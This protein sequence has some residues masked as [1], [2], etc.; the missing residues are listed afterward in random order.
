[1]PELFP[2]NLDLSGRRTL[3]VGGGEVA[4]RKVQLLIAAGATVIVVSPQFCDGLKGLD[5]AERVARPFDPADLKGCTL[6]IAATD[7]P[8][9]NRRVCEEARLK[10]VLVN[11]VDKPALCDFYVAASIRRGRFCV[12]ISTGGASPALARRVRLGLEKTFPPVYA[13]FVDLLAELRGEVQQ[14][15]DDAKRRG[16]ILGQLASEEML[17][18]L[19]TQGL[20]AAREAARELINRAAGEC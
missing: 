16:E 20:D 3:V 9:V 4:L 14:R 13:D 5:G 11:V 18:V 12:A 19:E 2:I 17:A 1:M 7:Q 6:A 10:G 8:E 15:I